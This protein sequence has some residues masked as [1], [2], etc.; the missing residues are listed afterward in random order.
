MLCSKDGLSAN[1]TTLPRGSEA[2][3]FWAGHRG[4]TSLAAPSALA[5]LPDSSTAVSHHHGIIP[6]ATP[7]PIFS[8]LRFYPCP[9]T[10]SSGAFLRSPHPPVSISGQRNELLR[11]ALS[12]DHARGSAVFQTAQSEY[13]QHICCSGCGASGHWGC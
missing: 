12:C 2:Y 1:G 4:L 8:K 9:S 6:Y 13:E 11:S 7:P 10:L 3:M 5:L